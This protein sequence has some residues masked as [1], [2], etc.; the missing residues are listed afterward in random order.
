MNKEINYIDL[1]SG[2]GGFAKGIEDAGIKIKN[3]YYSEIDKHCIAVY[4]KIS[5]RQSNLEISN[6]LKLVISPT[7][8]QRSDKLT[9]LPLDFHAKIYQLLAKEKVLMET[10]V[11]YFLK[12][13]GLLKKSSLQLLSLK[14]SKDFSQITMEKTLSDVCK[15]LATSGFM[16]A[17][18]NLLILA[19]FYPKIESE[20]ILL[21][22][23]EKNPDSKYFLSEKT[24]ARLLS[25]KDNKI[26]NLKQSRTQ[27]QHEQ[28]KQ[29]ALEHMLLKVNSMKKQ[30]ETHKVAE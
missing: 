3:H 10:E 19:G 13:L 25:Y 27:S 6:Q 11:D 9:S 2:I 28:A 17:N 7:L 20:Y 22:I 23:L 18:G 16:T 5:P 1:F 24:I 21:D 8:S 29:R 15:K 12:P 30:K 14:M 4:E 26:V